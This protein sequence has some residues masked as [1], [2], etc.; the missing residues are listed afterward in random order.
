MRKSTLPLSILKT[1]FKL[2]LICSGERRLY[3]TSKTVWQEYRPPAAGDR[4]ARFF[5]PRRAPTLASAAELPGDA[6]FDFCGVI[7]AVGELRIGLIY[8][9][10]IFILVK[11]LCCH[12][13]LSSIRSV[14]LQFSIMQERSLKLNCHQH[15]TLR[16]A[17]GQRRF[18][19]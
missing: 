3:C 17:V 12:T 7:A 2:Q 6:L 13:V 11:Q 14:Q 18:N 19:N 4:L 16:A 8:L 9:L 5:H 15:T 1:P 10:L